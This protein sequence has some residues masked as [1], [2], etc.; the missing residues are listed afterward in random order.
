MRGGPPIVS[1]EHEVAS[2]YASV[3]P[4]RILRDAGVTIIWDNNVVG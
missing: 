2:D 4:F 3:P 1:G